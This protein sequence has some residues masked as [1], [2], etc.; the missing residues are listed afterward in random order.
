MSNLG[1]LVVTLAFLAGAF[2]AVCDEEA[3]EWAWFLPA[4]TTGVIGIALIRLGKAE[5]TR[6]QEVLTAN[7][8][9]VERSLEAI[10]ENITALNEQK[11]AIDPYQ[12]RFR[13]DPASPELVIEPLEEVQEA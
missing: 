7:I 11:D 10:V 3:V 2:S 1:Y 4:L 9:S 12:V 8:E 5:K 6:S 13:L